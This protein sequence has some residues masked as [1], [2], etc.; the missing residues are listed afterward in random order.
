VGARCAPR[1]WALASTVTVGCIVV[2]LSI[3]GIEATPRSGLASLSGVV[4]DA[5]GRLLVGSV[6]LLHPLSPAGEPLTTL[7]LEDG[8]YLFSG[9]KQGTYRVTALRQGY[10][11][12]SERVSTLL[13]S[14]LDLVLSPL[15]PSAQSDPDLPGDKDWI[16]RLPPRDILRELDPA[17]PAAASAT[18]SSPPQNGR[19]SVPVDGE[20]QQWF[21]GEAP[22]DSRHGPIESSSGTSTSLS[23]AVRLRNRIDLSLVGDREREDA[24]ISAGSATARSD[25]VTGA[26]RV[27]FAIGYDVGPVSRVGMRASY[28]RDSQLLDGFDPGFS[29]GPNTENVTRAMGTSWQT[30]LGRAGK[31]DVSALYVDSVSRAAERNP[32][33][34]PAV[35]DRLWRAGGLLT[36]PVG[37]EHLVTVGLRARMLEM[38]AGREVRGLAGPHA[39]LTLGGPTPPGWA[40][41]IHGSEQ[42]AMSSLLSIDFGLDYHRSFSASEIAHLVPQ[43]GVLLHPTRRTSIKAAVSYLADS[44]TDASLDGSAM[45]V[46]EQPVV[47]RSQLGYDVRLERDAEDKLGIRVSA[48]SRPIAYEYGSEDPLRSLVG[49]RPIYVADGSARSE[50][51]GVELRRRLGRVTASVGS[52]R[53]RIEGRYAA[54]LPGR[55]LQEMRDGRLD[56]SRTS[57]TG[58]LVQSGTELR[59]ET[60]ALLEK[61]GEALAE[62]AGRL[63]S[64]SLLLGQDLGFVH[65]GET[66]W[67]F[68]LA[69]QRNRESRPDGEAATPSICR[70]LAAENSLSGGVSVQ[71]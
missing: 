25:R 49:E 42:W 15:M 32:V 18:S 4:M 26:D 14:R 60:R 59:I 31:L 58:R 44:R 16:L 52:A 64:L 13:R 41:H 12:R 23:L 56:Y 66:R 24:Q 40:V 30:E 19:M 34:G 45:S 48:S 65:L 5:T 57:L 71:F 1:A 20:L 39:P 54:S 38:P 67:R 53:G 33:D 8:N 55:P 35:V 6:V 37:A 22:L 62:P 21:S 3:S 69:F 50:E 9:L 68:M 61:A 36:T 51:I 7:T 43:A 17:S 11:A 27:G 10:A 2:M 47:S 70:A 29:Q 46:G 28:L 63:S